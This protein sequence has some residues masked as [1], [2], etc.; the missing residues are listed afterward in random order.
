[1]EIELI[2]VGILTLFRDKVV[3]LKFQSFFRS[4]RTSSCMSV[5]SKTKVL[6]IKEL[7]IERHLSLV[8]IL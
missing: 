3:I 5:F 2:F 8:K 1:M 7:P 4:A 6:A